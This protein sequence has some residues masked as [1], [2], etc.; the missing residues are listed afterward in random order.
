MLTKENKNLMRKYLDSLPLVKE[1]RGNTTYWFLPESDA[2]EWIAFID[3]IV[4]RVVSEVKVNEHPRFGPEIATYH[5]STFELFNLFKDA[6][7]SAM[8]QAEKAQREYHYMR[9]ERKIEHVRD[10]AKA[11]E[12]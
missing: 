4:C 9:K 1:R 11:Y 10:C 5:S 12:V 6:V 3:N 2:D 7:D 8:E